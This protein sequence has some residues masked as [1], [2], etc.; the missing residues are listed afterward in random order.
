LKF[1]LNNPTYLYSEGRTVICLFLFICLFPL[2]I[3][4]NVLVV[5]RYRGAD[6][7]LA[8]PGR[9]QATATKH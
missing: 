7:P 9:K 6:K 1:V 4:K 5:H 2:L 3:F 8:R